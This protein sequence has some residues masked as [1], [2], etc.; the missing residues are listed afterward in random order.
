MSDLQPDAFGVYVHIPFCAKRCDYCAFATWTDRHHLHQAYLA[1]LRADIERTVGRPATTVF[2]GGGTPTMVDPAGLAAVIAV[3]PAC[4]PGAEVTVECNPDDITAELL[5]AYLARRCQPGQH[6]RAVD[7]AAGA[8]LARSV[9]S[10]GQRGA[11]RRAREGGRRAHLEHGP[12][13]RRGGRD[14]RAL[15][16]HGGGVRSS[17]GRRTCRRT[18]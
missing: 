16:S 12:D 6:R 1:A 18:R 5:D 8:R 2:I 10:A 15:G 11:G 3:D 13:L 14:R 9:A 17:S 4:R 7:G